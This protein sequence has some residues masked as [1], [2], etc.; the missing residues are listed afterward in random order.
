MSIFV[1][2]SL[3]RFQTSHNL[4]IYIYFLT[5]HLN[6]EV[7]HVKWHYHMPMSPHAKMLTLH[8]VLGMILKNK[9]KF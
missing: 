3:D 8:L 4:N 9:R 1:K 2:K 6:T 5:W 7:Y